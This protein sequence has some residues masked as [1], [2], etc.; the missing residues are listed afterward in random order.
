MIVKFL[1]KSASF[2]GVSYNTRKIDKN[3]GELMKVSGFG[4]LQGIN[5]LRPKDYINYLKAVSAQNPRV[6]LPQL[7]LAIST[8]GRSHSG[9]QLTE[10]AE[11]WLK[12]MG[13]GEQPYLIIFHK[14]TANNHV[15]VVSTRVDKQ[16]KKISSAYEKLRAM[17]AL[18]RV[19]KM[20]EVE[21]A[22]A[23]LD[24]ALS[25]NF[26]TKAQFM[27]LLEARGYAVREF[28]GKFQLI[29]S[30]KVVH[31]F[32][33]SLV[34]DQMKSYVFPELRQKQ[35]TAVFHRYAALYN[36]TLVQ[37]VVRLPRGSEKK[38]AGYHSDFSIY[39]KE[40]FGWELIF[41]GKPG[42]P[43]YGYT[44]IDHE[45]KQVF[46]GKQVMDMKALLAYEVQ[47]DPEVLS[48]VSDKIPLRSVA[49]GSYYP[50]FLEDN[51]AGKSPVSSD[52][53]LDAFADQDATLSSPINISISDDID[54]EA[55]HGRNRQRKRQARTNTR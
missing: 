6:K 19:M 11:Q 50:L 13:Y 5:G 12:E 37:D 23:D 40:A 16:G 47:V 29:R 48:R 15:H 51:T 8:K 2:K 30:A 55:I 43:A 54:D 22:K 41:H 10:I 31:E 21:Q 7:H 34:T 32:N 33:A 39:L 52:W 27:L 9:E 49:A 36:T 44:I 53:R 20:D 28:D 17:T 3:K 1:S 26:S 14:D 35:M 25:Y 18:H 42:K 46:K 45:Q 38:G 24:V 4:P